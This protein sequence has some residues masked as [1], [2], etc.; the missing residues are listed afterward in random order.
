[1]GSPDQ[2]GS[3]AGTVADESAL[4]G[5]SHR[6]LDE[7]PE[8][9]LE[10]SG[11]AAP[12]PDLVVLNE[13]LV[14]ELGLDADGL[15]SEHGLAVL[16]G[17]EAP[18]GSHPVAL[19]YAGHQFGN[20]S[21]RLGDGRALLLGELATRSGDL[22]DVHLKGSGRTPF[23]RGGDGRA[24]VA[25]MLREYVIS[26]FMH[27][28]GVPTTR[29]L[30]VVRTGEQ[31]R[32]DALEPGAVLARTAASHV[33]VGTFEYALRL[34]AGDSA[35]DGLIGRLVRHCIQRHYPEHSAAA[36]DGSAVSERSGAGG[37]ALA[38]EAVALLDAVVASQA[39]LVS[40][41]MLL[42]FVHGVM[43]TDNMTI[44]GET[45][46][47]GPCAFVDQYDPAAV[48]SSIDQTGRY[49]FANQPGIASWNLA[50]L[51]ET[52]LGRIAAEAGSTVDEVVEPVTEVVRSFAPRFQGEFRSGMAAKLGLRGEPA[53][54]SGLF[55]D[56]LAVMARDSLDWTSTFRSL[57]AALRT[58]GARRLEADSFAA[59][60]SSGR[61]QVLGSLIGPGT[62][63]PS[64]EFVGWGARWFDALR[65]EGGD[66]GTVADAMDGINPLYIPRNHLVEEALQAANH[67]DTTAFEALMEVLTD[68]YRERSGADRC[69]RPAPPG[70]TEGYRT[71]CGT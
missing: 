23:A 7:L 49:A 20:Y 55:D 4:A 67:G 40:G 2:P 47:Y 36:R 5:L 71:F 24:T 38:G 54:D 25:P 61:S 46:D 66:P 63:A 28:V 34:Q 16:S 13:G 33:R 10:W 37:D 9:C 52:L 45:I 42:G 30:A 32:R 53:T 50:R 6:F 44:S 41:W 29:S 51:A 43:N 70:F 18:K 8:L 58:E 60:V 69:A 3:T 19:A 31:V 48:F 14:D 27:A 56:L 64:A 39:R 12:D 17:S 59:A 21:P 68:P 35:G 26:E 65:A 1:M 62:E 22:L 15:R 57:A 11:A